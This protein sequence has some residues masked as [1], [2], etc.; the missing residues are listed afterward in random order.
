MPGAPALRAASIRPRRFPTGPPVLK[1]VTQL[2][3]S[4]LIYGLGDVATSLFSLLLLPIFTSYL[5]PDDYGVITMLLTIEAVTKVLFRWGVDT[6]FMRLYFDC[7]DHVERQRLASTV[8][9]F[10]LAVN[11]A[12]LVFGVLSADRL[13]SLVFREGGRGLLIA[14]TIANTFVAGFYF[15]PFQV[16]R[17]REQS[18]QFVALAFA[19]SAGTIVAR[20]ALVIWAGLGVFGIVLAD[21]MVTTGFALILVRWYAPLIRPV[22]S[23]A[24]IREALAFGLPR[25]PH[26]VAHQVLGFADR[27]LLNLWGTLADVGL[28][29][30]GATFGLALKFFLSAFEA[31]W[32]PFFLGVMRE[33]DARRTY[34]TVSTYVVALLVLLVA[35]VCTTAP[36]VVQLFTTE[37]FHSAAAVTPWIAL[38]VMFQGLYLVGSIGLVITKRTKWY[39]VSTGTAAA[40]SLLANVILIPRFGMM[41]AA[42]ANAMAYGALAVLTVG[43][44]WWV[45]PIRYEWGRLFRIAVAGGLAYGVTTRAL[46]AGLAPVVA[47]IL[48]AAL[49]TAAYGVV[50]SLTGFFHP[51]ELRVLQEIRGRLL[52]RRAMLPQA[53]DATQVEMAGEIV[54]TA[55]ES[56][57]GESSA[58][59]DPEPPPSISPGSRSTDH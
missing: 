44:S 51:G 57:A 53:V 56:A 3:R 36:G 10:L 40:V 5:G 11:G 55:P 47:V 33:P 35:G 54:A 45:Y 31:A 4:L 42:W 1:R 19:R 30:I 21:V 27:Y 41:G 32:T 58:G 23:R 38:G 20:L 22:F 13:S 16:L 24:V 49:T 6:A 14:L 46:P 12:L 34:S 59:A 43:F 29:S 8:F 39:P 7:A 9:F 28:Y 48:S 50:L 37:D 17:I 15:I 26:S 18:G 52:E 2:F 25:V